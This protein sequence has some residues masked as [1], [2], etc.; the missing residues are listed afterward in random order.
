[1]KDRE[2]EY[3]LF[4]SVLVLVCVEAR[5][6]IHGLYIALSNSKFQ[7]YNTAIN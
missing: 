1:M 4:W 6:T 7:T 5:V 3:K 2:K